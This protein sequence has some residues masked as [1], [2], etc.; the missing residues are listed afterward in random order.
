MALYQ[1]I[2]AGDIWGRPSALGP[3]D[4][5]SF[6]VFPFFGS[7]EVILELLVTFLKNESVMTEQSAVSIGEEL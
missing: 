5:L 2:G 7:S 3:A 1:H 4:I 6:S